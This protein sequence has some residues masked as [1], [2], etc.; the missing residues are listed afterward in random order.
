MD[1]EVQ[2]GVPLSGMPAA[3]ISAPGFLLALG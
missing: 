3:A 2:S 1:P